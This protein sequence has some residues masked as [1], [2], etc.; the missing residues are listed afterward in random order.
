MSVNHEELKRLLT[1]DAFIISNHARTRMFQRDIS[2]E[3]V[4]EVIINGQII[5][6]YPED[7]PCPSALFFAYSG[8]RPCHVVIAECE[9]HARII[10][11]YIPENNKWI[12]YI[13]RRD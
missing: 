10:T 2:T 8:G 4:I 9:D 12:D 3:N 1:E 13:L 5:E 7:E 11:V 6:D